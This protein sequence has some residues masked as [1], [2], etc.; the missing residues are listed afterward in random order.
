[1]IYSTTGRELH[2]HRQHDV[3]QSPIV[4]GTVHQSPAGTS[5]AAHAGC[6]FEVGAHVDDEV[7]GT[8]VVTRLCSED[9][10]RGYGG[11]VFVQ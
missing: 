2:A 1:M 11:Q 5:F 4:Q 7:F 9:S 10:Y 6:P 8:G 3:H